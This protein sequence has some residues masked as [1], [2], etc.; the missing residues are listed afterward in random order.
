MRNWIAIALLAACLPGATARSVDAGICGP[1]PVVRCRRPKCCPCVVTRVVKEVVY[2]EYERTEYK[3]IFEEV[4]EEEEICAVR[5]VEET[6][7]R[8]GVCVPAKRCPPSPCAPCGVQPEP[9]IRK[10]PHTVYR[11]VCEKKTVE[12]P[13]IVERRVPYTVTCLKPRIIYKEV[14]V[15]VCCPKCCCPR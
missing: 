5:Y 12:V 6:E 10:A 4:M 3:T 7:Y 9:C 2:D 14:Q 8:P 11:A 1:R 15:T 13:R